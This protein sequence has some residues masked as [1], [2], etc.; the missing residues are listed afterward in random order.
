MG[1]RATLARRAVAESIGTATSPSSCWT[2]VLRDGSDGCGAS[3]V[4]SPSTAPIER[5]WM[6]PMLM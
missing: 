4:D 1:E 6:R 3:S 2:S 5:P